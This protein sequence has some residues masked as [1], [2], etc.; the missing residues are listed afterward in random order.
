MRWQAFHQVCLF[1]FRLMNRNK[2]ALFFNLAFPLLML[3][4]LATLVAPSAGGTVLLLPGLMTYMLLSA[5]LVTV[6]MALAIQRETGAHRHLFSTPLPLSLWV[7]GRVLAS[8]ALTA[9]QLL[10]LYGFAIA[11]YR[12][13]LPGNIGGTL[14][15]AAFSTLASTGLGVLIGATSRRSESALGISMILYMGFAAI[16]GAMMPLDMAPAAFQTIARFTPGYYIVDGMSEVAVLGHGLGT[17]L[18]HL[19]VLGGIGLLAMGL[20][21]WQLRRQTV[22]A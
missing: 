2:V 12:V 4:I 5:G 11:I 8:L 7:T 14:L 22:A 15:L 17:V 19:A 13:P 10:V 6:S 9:L 16:G 20:G 3:L 18:V 1:Q 21:V